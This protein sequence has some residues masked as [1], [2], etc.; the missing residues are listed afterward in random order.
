ML[1]TSIVSHW[2]A[3]RAGAGHS[4]KVGVR[5]SSLID[6]CSAAQGCL[7]FALQRS[8][9]DD[10]VWVITGS[11]ADPS[12]M[13]DWFAAPELNLF[14]ELLTERLVASLDFQTFATVTAD[15][16]RTGYRAEEVRL[17]G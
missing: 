12:A 1:D 11:W 13:N 4:E 10:D 7:H 9:T 5:L 6:S 17:A 14:S 2:V 16:A 15:Q 8:L 3:I